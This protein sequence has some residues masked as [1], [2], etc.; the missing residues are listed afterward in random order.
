MKLALRISSV[1]VVFVGVWVATY[2]ALMHHAAERAGAYVA[3]VRMGSLM[4]GLFAGG[5]AATLLLLALFL[6]PSGRAE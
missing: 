3:E 5:L 1:V 2:R 4:G 6:R